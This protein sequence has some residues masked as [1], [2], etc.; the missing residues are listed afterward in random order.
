MAEALEPLRKKGV[1]AG[2]LLDALS[3]ASKNDPAVWVKL[4]PLHGYTNLSL[5]DLLGALL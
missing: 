1:D 5:T 4:R 3:A 2:D